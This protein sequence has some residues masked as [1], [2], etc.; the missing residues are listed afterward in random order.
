MAGII[1]IGLVWKARLNIREVASDKN[2]ISLQ[3]KPLCTYRSERVKWA[4]SVS[5]LH[6]LD[7]CRIPLPRDLADLKGEEGT[8]GK[9]LALG[10]SWGTALL[11]QVTL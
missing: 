8:G 6:S 5:G 7:V 9:L 10:S 11:C 4:A 3:R 2:I 1:N